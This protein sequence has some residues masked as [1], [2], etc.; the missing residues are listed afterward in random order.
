MARVDGVSLNQTIKQALAEA[1]ARRRE[2]PAFKKRLRRIIEKDREL[3]ER[4]AQ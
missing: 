4:L 2:D 1:V 3:L